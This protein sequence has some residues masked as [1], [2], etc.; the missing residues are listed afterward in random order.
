MGALGERR[1]SGGQ[2]LDFGHLVEVEREKIRNDLL[3]CKTSGQLTGWLLQFM[4]KASRKG[5]PRVFSEDAETF[6]KFIF[7][8][9]NAER[10][11]NLL[12]F[13]LVSYSSEGVKSP[14]NPDNK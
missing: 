14:S 6:R 9:R 1:G 13:A 3:R 11:Q 2:K 5:T 8:P 7:N 4:N 12:L 10:L